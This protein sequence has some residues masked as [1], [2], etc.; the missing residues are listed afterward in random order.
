[1]SFWKKKNKTRDMIGSMKRF[2]TAMELNK[3]WNKP[4][5]WTVLFVDFNRKLMDF[6]IK[7]SAKDKG[8]EVNDKNRKK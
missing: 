4:G 5:D 6:S 3:I 2:R 8:V 7:G 1:M